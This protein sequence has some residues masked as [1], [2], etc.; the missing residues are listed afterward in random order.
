MSSNP[1]YGLR[2]VG[3]FVQL[4]GAAWPAAVP[5]C[6]CRLHAVA[7]RLTLLVSDEKHIRGVYTRRCAIQITT[8]FTFNNPGKVVH[9]FTHVPLTPSSITWYRPQV[10]PVYGKRLRTVCTHC[11]ENIDE[12]CSYRS[13]GCEREY[14]WQF[15]S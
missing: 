7:V 4:T 10:T 2:K 8:F 3:T 6:V 11:H 14:R 12:H 1:L 5:A 9:M 13:Q 15:Q